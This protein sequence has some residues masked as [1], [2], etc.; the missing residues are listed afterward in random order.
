LLKKH[1]SGALVVD[2]E[3]KLVGIL[4]EHDCVA[5]LA[6]VAADKWPT[7]HVSEKMPTE[8]ETVPPTEDVFALSTRFCQGRH[9]RLLV[10]DQGKLVGLSSRRDLLSELEA[11]V[12][13][14]A[15]EHRETTYGAI[16]KRH[17]SL[18]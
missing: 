16:E 9:R 14:M 8:V 4:S 6:Q 1:H 7:G 15:Y 3:G 10:V 11:L 18:D 13:R 2:S 17:I 12:T 5:V